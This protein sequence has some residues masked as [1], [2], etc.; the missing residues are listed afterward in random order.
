MSIKVLHVVD[1]M[2]L[3]GAQRG[4]KDILESELF[5]CDH[6]LYVLRLVEDAIV[7]ENAHQHIENSASKFSLM[8]ILGLKKF[9]KSES[10]E[11]LH[12]H[13]FR[14][15]VF[16]W[17]VKKLFFPKL[18]LIFHERGNIYENRLI[19]RTFLKVASRDVS[20]FI[21]VS[22][23]TR[24]KLISSIGIPGNKV[25]GLHNGIDIGKLCKRIPSVEEV[26]KEK[27]QLG[28][29]S[30]E[31]VIGF[32]GRLTQQ[33]GCEYLIE[34]CSMLD[35][36]F[37]LVMLGEGEKETELKDLVDKYKLSDRVVFAGYRED[38]T[39][40]YSLF[41][42]LA[43]P[44]RWEPYPRSLLEA[45]VLQLPIVASSVD[46]IPEMITHEKTGL[47]FDNGNVQQLA[48]CL[49]RMN[50]TPE[51]LKEISSGLRSKTEEISLEKFLDELTRIYG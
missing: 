36:P 32:A 46:G 31:F 15:Q 8:P 4:I 3:G 2:G 41:D 28:L 48:S 10:V 22:H 6:G 30:N 23:A 44:S 20:K 21:T 34:A 17:L 12:C 27:K 24:E 5:S 33:K 13:L 47:L 43:L 35:F 45:I 50:E 37:K 19:D 51:L 26:E 40:Y 1:Q 11:I 39:L 49:K 14:S 9:I 18:R 7:V 42:V 29:K 16:G 25:V 38:I